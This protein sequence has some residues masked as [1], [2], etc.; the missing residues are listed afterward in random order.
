MTMAQIIEKRFAVATRTSALLFAVV[1]LR[2]DQQRDEQRSAQSPSRVATKK[3]DDDGVVIRRHRVSGAAGGVVSGVQGEYEIV[4]RGS[5]GR[6][7][8]PLPSHPR[9]QDLGPKAQ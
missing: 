3:L 1:S 9:Y 8:G 2:A 6:G 4:G 7:L 5:G